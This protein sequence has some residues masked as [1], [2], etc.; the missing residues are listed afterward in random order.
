MPEDATYTTPS[1]LL[2]ENFLSHMSHIKI[3]IQIQN[4]FVEHS[5]WVYIEIQEYET[6]IS[7]FNSMIITRHILIVMTN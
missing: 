1:L 5:T 4:I 7:L 3:Q 6:Q 2:T